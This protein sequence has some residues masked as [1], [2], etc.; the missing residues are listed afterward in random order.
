MPALKGEVQI[1]GL[2][3]LVADAKSVG[4]SG[5]DKVVRAALINSMTEI[6]KQAR[7]R[8]PH[9]TGTLQRSILPELNYPTAIVAVNEKYG[10][11]L[12]EGTGPYDIVPKNK[13]ALFWKGAAHPVKRVHH[14]GL[15]ARPFFWPGVEAS[16]GFIDN[17]FTIVI[18]RLT[19]A[20][21]GRTKI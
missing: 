8:A 2:K 1:V 9:R 17:Q 14:P 16:K 7:E 13:K 10:L 3:E 11:Y 4:A 20:L 6:Q 5:A 19:E 18:S 21:A 12:E 15:K